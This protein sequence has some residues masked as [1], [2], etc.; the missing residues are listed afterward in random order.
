V[1]DIDH[2]DIHCSPG[3]LLNWRLITVNTYLSEYIPQWIH[4]CKLEEKSC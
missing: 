2:T 3:Q 1:H 4:T